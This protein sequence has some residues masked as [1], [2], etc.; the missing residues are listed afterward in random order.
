M[1]RYLLVVPFLI[2]CGGAET[3]PADSAAAAP[4]ALTEAD[5][6]GTWSGTAMMEGSD[7]V[8]AN[9]SNM[10]SA[11]TCLFTTTQMPADTV[12]HTYTLEADSMRGM[13]SAYAEATMG[14]TM[15]VDHWVARLSGNQVTGTGELRLAAMPDSVLAR[16]RFIGTKGM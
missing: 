1:R 12:T 3:P 15:V 6:A 5:L 16:Y 14:G 13:S 10:C 8:F 4:A 9:W 7:S 11:G 2:A